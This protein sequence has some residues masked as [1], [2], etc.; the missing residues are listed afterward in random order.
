MIKKYFLLLL[1][2]LSLI[3]ISNSILTFYHTYRIELL[4]YTAMI[5]LFAGI[6]LQIKLIIEVYKNLKTMKL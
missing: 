4:F 5:F 1:L 6:F 2:N 3:Y